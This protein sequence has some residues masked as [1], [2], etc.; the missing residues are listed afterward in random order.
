MTNKAS[1]LLYL[2]FTTGQT[3]DVP[4]LSLSKLLGANRDSTQSLRKT[5][6]LLIKHCCHNKHCGHLG[7]TECNKAVAKCGLHQTVKVA[8]SSV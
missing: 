6:G 4:L 1:Q 3:V 2:G 7:C 8:C 5:V